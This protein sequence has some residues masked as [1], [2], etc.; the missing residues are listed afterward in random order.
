MYQSFKCIPTTKSY[1]HLKMPSTTAIYDYLKD[2]K[3]HDISDLGIHKKSDPY[4]GETI[5]HHYLFQVD[6]PLYGQ[7]SISIETIT[8]DNIDAKWILRT[9]YGVY[10]TTE[11]EYTFDETYNTIKCSYENK[12]LFTRRIFSIDPAYRALVHL[13]K[14][15]GIGID[16]PTKLNLDLPKTEIK[17]FSEITARLKDHYA[18]I[19][20]DE[21]DG[22][23]NNYLSWRDD[24]TMLVKTKITD[25]ASYYDDYD[26]DF[27][28][29]VIDPKIE[30]SCLMAYECWMGDNPKMIIRD[31]DYEIT[32]IKD[33]D[34]APNDEVKAAIHEWSALLKGKIKGLGFSEVISRAFISDKTEK[35]SSKKDKEDKETTPSLTNT[36]VDTAKSPDPTP[37]VT[38]STQEE[39]PAV[40]TDIDTDAPFWD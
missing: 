5:H 36:T 10:R 23:L 21:R 6:H 33:N 11:L 18:C 4:Q 12:T 14:L 17:P 19:T 35:K 29:L 40:T 20:K 38:A 28:I 26:Y 3:I 30:G 15:T 27:A 39:S 9:G 34:E 31:S 7:S 25:D 16:I 2:S 1:R 22:Y 24:F 8:G 13:L 37:I 32:G